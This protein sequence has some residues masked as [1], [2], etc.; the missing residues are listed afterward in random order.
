MKIEHIGEG[1]RT[2]GRYAKYFVEM[3]P[4]REAMPFKVPGMVNPINFDKKD[5]EKCTLHFEYF[6]WY[7]PGFW[8][9]ARNEGDQTLPNGDVITVRAMPHRHPH[10]EIFIFM[11]TDPNNPYELGGE[12]EFWIG[13]GDKAEKYSITKT[14]VLVVPKGVVHNPNSCLWADRPYLMLVTLNTT[15]HLDEHV[16]VPKAFYDAHEEL[17]RNAPLRFDLYEQ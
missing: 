9:G 17:E 10:E 16:E 5:H 2:G 7:G 8:I 14:T 11:G 13:E 6:I 1:H 4:E 3:G 15:E 12:H